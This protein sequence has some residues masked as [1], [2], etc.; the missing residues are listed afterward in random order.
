VGFLERDFEQDHLAE[1]SNRTKMGRFSRFS[2]RGT[3]QNS[4]R[5]ITLKKMRN[6]K[7]IEKFHF[8]LFLPIFATF[9][10]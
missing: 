3:H 10:K 9:M 6:F 4:F 5:T 2:R 7:N 8:C 1:K